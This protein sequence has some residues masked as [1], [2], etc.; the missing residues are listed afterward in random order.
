MATRLSLSCSETL[1]WQNQGHQAGVDLQVL[2]L[3]LGGD[4]WSAST[5]QGPGRAAAPAPA[6]GLT[7]IISQMVF[8]THTENWD[9]A[10]IRPHKSHCWE[11][12]EQ[13]GS[14]GQCHG[15]GT[16]VN[17]A[18]VA[19]T[20]HSQGQAWWG[21]RG[22]HV[23]QSGFPRQCWQCPLS[24]QILCAQ[25]EE[26]VQPGPRGTPERNAPWQ[27]QHPGVAG[28]PHIHQAPWDGLSPPSCHPLPGWL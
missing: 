9:L 13:R 12:A 4:S 23:E 16:R 14:S 1:W 3:N 10:N 21:L 25:E 26:Q 20:G 19:P 27:S 18:L 28:G 22:G 15:T 5:W 7:G 11:R 17:P 8:I 24:A 6:P 2:A